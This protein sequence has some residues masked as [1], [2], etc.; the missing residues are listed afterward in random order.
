[1]IQWLIQTATA[2]PD[3]GRP[4]P[5]AGLLAAE[6][7]ERFEGL[8]A[9]KRKQDWLLG[10][11][12]AKHLLQRML[13]GQRGRPVPLDAIVIRPAPSGAPQPL[14]LEPP[15]LRAVALPVAL[16]I[17][18]REDVSVCAACLAPA[19]R[20]G[21]D[22]EAVEPRSSRFVADYFTDRERALVEQVEAPERDAIA[23]VIWSSKEAVLKTLGLGLTVDTRR[24]CCLPELGATEASWAPV[25]VSCDPALLPAAT[26]HDDRIGAV[27]G[28]WRRR[29]HSVLSMA[30]LTA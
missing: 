23:N 5:P 6:E 28:W 8:R 19:V 16:S 7:Q 12:T 27:R 17:T 30:A 21:V 3:L 15:A 9:T 4:A 10:R 11:W 14:L 24:V 26:E 22:L 29:E 2:H 20:L 1:M 13:T 25:L 18:H